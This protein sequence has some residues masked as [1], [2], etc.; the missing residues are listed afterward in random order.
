M[1]IVINII[2]N[3]FKFN[4]IDSNRGLE[5]QLRGSIQKYD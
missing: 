5:L 2:N 1:I 3:D 4:Y